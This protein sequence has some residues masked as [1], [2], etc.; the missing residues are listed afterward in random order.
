MKKL[1]LFIAALCFS[2]VALAERYDVYIH[3]PYR[4]DTSP[5]DRI[6]P[7]QLPDMGKSF[8]EGRSIRKAWDERKAR[9]RQN[10]AMQEFANVDLSNQK[11]VM[12]YLQKY[13]EQI[14][15]I[16]QAIS[17]NNSIR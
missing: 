13:P 5:Y 1:S 12:A 4:F 11:S 3:E 17:L 2:S 14:D 8:E 7:V 6:Q 15:F 10:E 9:K 16:R